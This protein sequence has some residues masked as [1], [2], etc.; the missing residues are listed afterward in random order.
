MGYAPL[1]V[2]KSNT[3]RWYML[4]RANYL[5]FFNFFQNLLWFN[6]LGKPLMLSNLCWWWKSLWYKNEYLYKKLLNL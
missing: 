6:F 3:Q 1:I 4:S 2:G 5:I